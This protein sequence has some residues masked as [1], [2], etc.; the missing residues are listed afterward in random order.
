MMNCL[1]VYAAGDNDEL[2]NDDD[3]SEDIYLL[4]FISLRCAS[5]NNQNSSLYSRKDQVSSIC[6]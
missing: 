6:F 3:E 4:K 2:Y 1:S 5:K